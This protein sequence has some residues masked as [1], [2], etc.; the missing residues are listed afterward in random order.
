MSGLAERSIYRNLRLPHI[1]TE[2]RRRSQER[3]SGV[4]LP[5][6][7]AAIESLIGAS[8]EYVKLDASRTVLTLNGFRPTDGGPSNGAPMM[9]T[10]VL[11]GGQER[12]AVTI[13]GQAQHVDA[14]PIGELPAPTPVEAAE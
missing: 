13:D 9:L 5:R 2:I 12:Q 14:E 4:A 11:A 3:I 8:S 7:V 1:Q 10:I 6:A